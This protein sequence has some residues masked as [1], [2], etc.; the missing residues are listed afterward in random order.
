M[1]E[2]ELIDMDTPRSW[3]FLGHPGDMVNVNKPMTYE[4]LG[5]MIQDYHFLD[6]VGATQK[7]VERARDKKAPPP[8]LRVVPADEPAPI[9]DR[10]LE[11]ILLVG[12]LASQ[13]PC[14]IGFYETFRVEPK[15]VRLDTEKSYRDFRMSQSPEMAELRA[16]VARLSSLLHA[17]M[18]DGHG[19]QITESLGRLISDEEVSRRI[20]LSMPPWAEGKWDCWREGGLVC[21]SI[22][23][24]G[25][26]GTARI[27]TSA[28]PIEPYVHEVVGYA[29][30]VGGN[31]SAMLGVLPTVA[32]MMAGGSLPP[33]MCKAAPSILARPEVQSGNIFIGRLA[34]ASQPA[35]AA[36]IA[37]LQ[38]AQNGDPQATSE[39]QKFTKLAEVSADLASTMGE[40]KIRLAAAQEGR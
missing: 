17:H 3:E 33:A 32:C 39:W 8:S 37:L 35:L 9:V 15:Y 31:I 26:D 13:F 4:F 40:A 6:V 36:M 10:F 12:D 11:E 25:A 34:G 16:E 14:T 18:A 19:P 27:C 2:T 7:I 1:H 38:K 20:P 29:H 22:R 24:P 28:T 23:L 30:E 21:C 5:A